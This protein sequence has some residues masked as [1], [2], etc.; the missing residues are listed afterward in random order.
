MTKENSLVSS[1]LELKAEM[2]KREEEAKLEKL[3]LEKEKQEHERIKKE[4]EAAEKRARLKAIAQEEARKRNQV[5]E[6]YKNPITDRRSN[7][8]KVIHKSNTKVFISIIMSAICLC[9][10]SWMSGFYCG[11]AQY[12]ENQDT[13]LN[14]DDYHKDNIVTPRY[15]VSPITIIKAKPKILK[16]NRTYKKK[17]IVKYK[18]I[19]TKLSYDPLANF[20]L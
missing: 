5:P 9:I 11:Q 17:K 19:T 18:K 2:L 7:S 6:F 12:T 13:T 8:P 10:I 16:K 20:N 15:I 3:R 4:K 1:V 14:M